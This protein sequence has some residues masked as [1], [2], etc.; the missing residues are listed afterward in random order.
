[1]VSDIM[2][3]SSF[4]I[5]SSLQITIGLPFHEPPSSGCQLNLF[6]PKSYEEPGWRN[7]DWLWTGRPRGQSSSPG[8]AKNFLISTSTRKALEPTR[9]PIQ[10]VPGA[11]S[12]GVKQQ[13]HEADRKPSA[14]TKV[15]KMWIYTSTPPKGQL[16]LFIPFNSKSYVYTSPPHK[17]SPQASLMS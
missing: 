5:V 4:I 17:K 14:S 13:G 9:P 16:Y 1:M 11:L 15:K 8:R 6:N 3:F 10:W 2:R 12:L 7:N